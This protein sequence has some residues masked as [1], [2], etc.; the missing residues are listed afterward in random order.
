MNSDLSASMTDPAFALQPFLTRDQIQQRVRELGAEISQDFAGKDL[1]L[2]GV[3][4]G[5]ALFLA[6]LSRSISIECT[7]DFVTL[8]SYGAERQTSGQVRQISIV[9]QKL[10]NKNVIIVEDILDTGITLNSLR[11]L[12]LTYKPAILKTVTLLDK[13]SRRLQSFQADYV[14]FQIPD[15][16]VVGYG[17]DA[18]ERYRNLPDIYTLSSD[19]QTQ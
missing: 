2:I 1:L 5:A 13:P 4:K 11:N 16:F 12:L 9:E 18:N 8:S 19:I 6:D 3:L 17:M 10:E 7:F 15:C 14:G